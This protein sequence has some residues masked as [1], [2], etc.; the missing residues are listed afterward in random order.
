MVTGGFRIRAAMPNLE[1]SKK[2]AVQGQ[3][4]CIPLAVV[5]AHCACA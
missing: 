1:V 4:T 3:S 2:A 5:V